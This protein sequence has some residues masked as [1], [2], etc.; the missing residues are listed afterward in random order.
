MAVDVIHNYARFINNRELHIHQ[1]NEMDI[2]LM[3]VF[4]GIHWEPLWKKKEAINSKRAAVLEAP[5]VAKIESCFFK[6]VRKEPFF[7]LIRLYGK[8]F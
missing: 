3:K 5:L 2:L 6:N 1:V 8:S 4:H 7:S